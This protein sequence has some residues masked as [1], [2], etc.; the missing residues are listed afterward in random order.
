[1]TTKSKLGKQCNKV[2]TVQSRAAVGAAGTAAGGM[3]VPSSAQF[4]GAVAATAPSFQSAAV[5]ANA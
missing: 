3:A 4:G 1:M 5:L 2:L